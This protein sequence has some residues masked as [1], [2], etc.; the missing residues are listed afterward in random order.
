MFTFGLLAQV[1]EDTVAEMLVG[2]SY[3]LGGVLATSRR[4]EVLLDRRTVRIAK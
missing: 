3:E 4:C 2:V 1:M